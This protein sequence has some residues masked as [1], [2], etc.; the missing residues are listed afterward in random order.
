MTRKKFFLYMSSAF[1]AIALAGFARSFYLR[2]Y[3]DFPELP[4]HLY[5][6]GAALTA[7]FVLAFIQPWL[8]K[9]RQIDAHRKLGVIGI[10][11]AF[12]VVASGVWTLFIRDASEI[13]EFPN[14][15]VGNIAPLLMFS[16]CFALGVLFRRQ[17]AVHKRLMLIASIPLLAPALDRLARIPALHEFFGPLLSWFPAP[18]EVAFATLAFLMLL[19]SVVVND[20]VSERRVLAG[21]Y[22]GLFS[23]L[24]I[25]PITSYAIA[26]TESWATFVRWVS[27][28]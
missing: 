15:A 4:M 20:L 27:Q 3:F 25:T 12:C 19:S 26:S 18:T 17:S 24:I 7:W 2:E 13:D 23:I 16:C 1:L 28:A 22:W 21:T 14:R 10:L 5:L 6:H 9:F 11:V 8:I